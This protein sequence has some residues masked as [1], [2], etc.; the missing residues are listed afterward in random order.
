[1]RQFAIDHGL[2][3]LPTSKA[4]ELIWR[5]NPVAVLPWWWH[6]LVSPLHVSIRMRQWRLAV[7]EHR[8]LAWIMHE[9]DL[10]GEDPA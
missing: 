8:H 2:H 4:G 5:Y 10:W 1:M 3:S 7:R 6:G 9:G